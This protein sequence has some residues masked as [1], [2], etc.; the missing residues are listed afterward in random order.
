MR[1]LAIEAAIDLLLPIGQHKNLVQFLLGLSN[2]ARVFALH[3][4]HNPRGHLRFFLLHQFPVANDVDA[5]TRI[6]VA[7]QI[8]I[9]RDLLVNFDDDNAP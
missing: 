6:N 9:Q 7:Q 4:I 2:T 1:R 5:D 3:H 8:Q